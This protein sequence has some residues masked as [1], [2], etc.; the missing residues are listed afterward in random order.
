ML[1]FVDVEGMFVMDMATENIAEVETDCI[2]IQWS[3][4]YWF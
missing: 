2:I 3:R 4:Y 1:M